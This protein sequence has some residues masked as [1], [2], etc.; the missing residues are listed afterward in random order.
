DP[1]NKCVLER[2]A[3]LNPDLSGFART[4][5]GNFLV[6]PPARLFGPF[7]APK[8]KSM[9][10]ALGIEP[11]HDRN[12]L[13]SELCGSCHTVRLPIL[14]RG[15]TIGHTYEQT[16]YPEWAFSGYRT[17]DSPDG[18]LPSGAGAR[19]QSCQDCHM[20]NKDPDGNPYRSKIAAIQ[21]DSNFPQ[22][23]HTLPP[24]DIDR[25]VRSPF[26]KHTLLGLNV[27]LLKMA[28]Q[29]P[30]VLGIRREDPM[31]TDSGIDSIPTAESAMLEQA[32]S[33]TAGITIGDVENDG[34]TLSARVTVINRVGH[35]FP[36]G[37]GFRRAFLEFKVLDA[38][39]RELWVSGRTNG[40]GV[41]VDEN[42]D[43]IEGE[44]WWKDDCSSRIDPDRR[45]HQRHHQQITRQSQAQ[46]Y[47][48][49][50]AAPP[51]DPAPRC[52]AHEP[53]KGRLTTS[54][55]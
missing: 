49:L 43:P 39:S 31:L 23:E 36:S 37:V 8:P 21:E 26:G 6:G 53:P 44:L 42:G 51:D 22:A 48:E 29:F 28:G 4:F 52:A 5:T 50:V 10:N 15:G 7:Q 54:F 32:A 12:I 47:Q 13:R 45:T 41:I 34:S 18:P 40:A 3:A 27:F 35:K 16:T 38:D 46:I 2:Q 30:E 1:Q 14:H 9:K 25:P 55:F 33:R 17:G 20:P 11:T 24:E 19:A